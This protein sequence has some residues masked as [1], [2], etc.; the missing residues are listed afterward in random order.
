MIDEINDKH[1]PLVSVIMNCKNCEK[2]L[3]EAVGSVLDQTYD[4]WEVIFWDNQSTDSSAAIFHTYNDARL[5][6][7]LASEYTPLG[8]ARNLAMQEAKGD[9]IAFLDCD[10]I[11][12]PQKLEKQIPVFENENVGLV[13]CD[14]VFFNEKRDVRQFYKKKKPPVGKVFRELLSSY[15]ISLET[16]IVRTSVLKKLD[17]WFDPRFDVIEEYDFFVRIGYV[18]EVGYVDEVLSKWRVHSS[19]WTWSR[20]ELFPAETELF[21]DKLHNNI[22]NFDTDYATE[23]SIVKSNIAIQE[24][25]IA[26]RD[27]KTSDV[28]RI[29]GP[30]FAK[31]LIATV[32]TVWSLL[33]PYKTFDFINNIRVGLSR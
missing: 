30:Y 7:F 20:P 21:V 11:W 25:I 17:H 13:I 10:D 15:F 29:L 2:Y 28:R 14:T 16:A 6:Y 26:W 8:E 22:P 5:K 4:N 33:L 27:G 12:F 24:S 9:Y 19:S 1:L 3:D 32:I 18:W 31:S 23:I